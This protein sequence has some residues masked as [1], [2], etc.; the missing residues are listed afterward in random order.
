MVA[1]DLDQI[2][3]IDM[4]LKIRMDIQQRVLVMEVLMEMEEKVMP[5]A[6]VTGLVVVVVG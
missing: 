2:L 5:L 3:L 6:V 1:Q 4:L